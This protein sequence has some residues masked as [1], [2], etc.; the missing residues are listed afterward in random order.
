MDIN[1]AVTN[2]SEIEKVIFTDVTSAEW[3]DAA[4]STG[5][6]GINLNV[7]RDTILNYT[8][9]YDTGLSV[10]GSA[11]YLTVYPGASIQFVEINGDYDVEPFV[12][13]DWLFGRQEY[14]IS[15]AS[16]ISDDDGTLI[17]EGFMI[18]NPAIVGQN[19]R[20]YFPTGGFY[21]NLITG[22]DIQ[23]TKGIN[24]VILTAPEETIL[25]GTEDTSVDWLVYARQWVNF[26]IKMTGLVLGF[27]VMLLAVIRFFFIDNLLLTVGL[28]IG[29]SMAYSAISTPVRQMPFGFFK[30]FIGFQRSMFGFMMEL[31]NYLIQIISAFRGIFRL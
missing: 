26:A 28:Y 2:A 18:H 16:N 23:S 3:S 10:T 12:D 14:V 17:S 4:N 19:I 5:I 13:L 7:P 15:Y 25:T 9:Y 30:K 27:V 22:V 29:V 1:T 20:A 31:W 24:I 6:Y 8:L 21:G 11:Y